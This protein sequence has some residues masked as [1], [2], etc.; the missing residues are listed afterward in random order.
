MPSN[1][2][3]LEAFFTFAA[4]VVL[5]SLFYA[6]DGILLIPAFISLITDTIVVW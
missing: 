5:S 3:M 6:L 1:F 4:T 2:Y